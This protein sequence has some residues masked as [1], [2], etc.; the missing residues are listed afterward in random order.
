VRDAQ[1]LAL[2]LAEMHLLRAVEAGRKWAVKFLLETRGK[3]RGY[4]REIDVHMNA[5]VLLAEF[6]GV[7]VEMLPEPSTTAIDPIAAAAEQ[8]PNVERRRARS[9]GP[10]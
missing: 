1:E 5:R 2:D 9:S 6:L 10:Q 7:P 4:G 3:H 8:L